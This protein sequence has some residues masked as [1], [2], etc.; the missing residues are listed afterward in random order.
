MTEIFQKYQQ[1]RLLIQCNDDNHYYLT[2]SPKYEEINDKLYDDIDRENKYFIGSIGDKITIPV[3][4]KNAQPSLKEILDQ[5]PYLHEYST[6][7]LFVHSLNYLVGQYYV[8][9]LDYTIHT[10]N[11][12]GD[13]FSQFEDNLKFRMEW[14]TPTPLSEKI[15]DEE[16]NR[17]YSIVTPI[18]IKKNTDTNVYQ[19]ATLSKPPFADMN[20]IAYMW[21][22]FND[23]CII[24]QYIPN[25]KNIM[26]LGGTLYATYLMT[27]PTFH[28]WAYYGFFKPSLDE[29]LRQTPRHVFETNDNIL[30][31]TDVPTNNPSRIIVG[32]YHVGVTTLWR[33]CE[34]KCETKCETNITVIS[35]SDFVPHDY[36]DSCMI[37]KTERST[38][39][40]IP[41]GHVV[42]CRSCANQ[43]N[44]S[45]CIKCHQMINK[46]IYS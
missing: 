9:C 15:L 46:V 45:T 20:H 33:V 30:V 40:V 6:V 37:C 17:R 12:H 10:G 23:E 42:I 24:G 26:S 29:V 5:I 25:S 35:D 39:M 32:D 7:Y 44:L 13:Y 3:I 38:S 21:Q 11:S 22:D 27:I 1:V 36:S 2:T 8:S 34:T 28:T 14:E 19:V 16:L 4:H 18:N 43:S 31:M 41:C